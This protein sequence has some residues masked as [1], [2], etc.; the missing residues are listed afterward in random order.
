MDLNLPWCEQMALFDWFSWIKEDFKV[1]SSDQSAERVHFR[2]QPAQPSQQ[3]ETLF[4]SQ[5]LP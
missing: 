5:S 4:S 1:R 2:A 3:L